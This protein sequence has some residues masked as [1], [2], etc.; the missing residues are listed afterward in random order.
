MKLNYTVNEKNHIEVEFIDEDYSIPAVIKDI[1]LKNKDV[2]FATYVI[3]HPS[4]DHPKLIIKTKK[5]NAR[6][7]FKEA[8]KEAIETFEEIKKEFSK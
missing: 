8:V 1:L 6:E 3:G 4:K 5:D 7:V 2:E